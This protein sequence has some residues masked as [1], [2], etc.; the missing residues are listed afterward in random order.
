LGW[1]PP[2]NMDRAMLQTAGHYQE[3]QT[4]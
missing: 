3:R 1:K 4:K 2:I